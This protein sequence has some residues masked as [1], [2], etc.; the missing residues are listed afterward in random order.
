MAS[1]T[2]HS[3][4]ADDTPSPEPT[5]L[6]GWRFDPTAQTLSRDGDT[7]SLSYRASQVLWRLRCADGRPVSRSELIAYAWP[8]QIPTDVALSQVIVELRKALGESARS[9]RHVLTVP[10]VGYRLA[11]ESE[12]AETEAGRPE[13]AAPAMPRSP[14]GRMLIALLL[15]AVLAITLRLALPEA[16]PPPHPS[17]ATEAA[18]QLLDGPRP[19]T[20]S[21]ATERMPHLGAGGRTLAF[22]VVRGADQ[23]IHLLDVASGSTSILTQGARDRW[24]R[25]SRDG[26][27]VAFF[28]QAPGAP[29]SELR[30]APAAGGASRLVVSADFLG[31][32]D[33]TPDGLA[34]ITAVDDGEGQ[35]SLHRVA[36][37]DGSLTA[38]DLFEPAADEQWI[39]D[40][41]FSPSGD[42]LIVRV[43]PFPHARLLLADWP[44]GAHRYLTEDS[45]ILAGHTW[46]D[47][48]HVLLSAQ[49]RG[50]N[51]LWRLD[52]DRGRWLHLRNDTLSRIS[53]S[54]GLL[55]FPRR[56]ANIS[57][58]A[59]NDGEGQAV[60]VADSAFDS[61][62]PRFLGGRDALLFLSMRSGSEQ[63]WIKQDGAGETRWSDLRD[64]IVISFD[65]SHDGRQVL[66]ALQADHGITLWTRDDGEDVPRP[67]DSPGWSRLTAVAVLPNRD[68]A[69][70]L[71]TRFDGRSGLFRMHRG[72]EVELL[73]EGDDF[74]ALQTTADGRIF[75]SRRSPPAYFEWNE[76]GKLLQ[77]WLTV[78]GNALHRWRVVDEGLV[79]LGPQ[80][81]D[82]PPAF[83][84]VREPGAEPEFLR[85]WTLPLPPA[86]FDYRAG[87]IIAAGVDQ[88]DVN[89]MLWDLR[90]ILDVPEGEDEAAE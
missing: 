58:H 74:E 5:R 24:P 85:S 1:S 37:A 25:L 2:P 83:V 8:G 70:A 19:A 39:S 43:G 65:V 34:L 41:E 80:G 89:L 20:S 4:A 35:V 46:G 42:R 64:A 48:H 77:P 79:Y 67:F 53:A 15:A 36:L 78:D 6:F 3:V 26:R 13:T 61:Y 9:P 28:R 38:L 57:L 17:S 54:G 49:A 21:G 55:V 52:I 29:E 72:G 73:Q 31:S 81:T 69:V 75:V 12:S 44:D 62:G 27:Y 82:Q 32:M 84:L 90:Q 59:F 11:Q 50:R 14:S 18:L 87:R 45:R 56:I 76:D 23:E 33:W 60:S 66:Y 63:F 88:L 86:S 10:R 30:V 47:E 16:P 71:G 22:A 51:A 7:R 40:P 68:D